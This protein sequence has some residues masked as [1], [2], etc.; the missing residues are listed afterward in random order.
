M[1]G[2]VEIIG[3]GGAIGG[4]SEDATA[5]S[6]RQ[7]LLWLN[8]AMRWDDAAAAQDYIARTRKVVSDLALGGE[9]DLRK[10]AQLRRDGRLVEASA[11]REIRPPW[12]DQGTV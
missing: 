10:H 7:Y 6:N 12:P 4:L 11:A 9:G 8:F 1:E 5:F 3:P 2:E